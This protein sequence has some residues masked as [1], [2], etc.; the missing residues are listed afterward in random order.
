MIQDEVLRGYLLDCLACR[1]GTLPATPALSDEDWRTWLRLAT[2]HRVGPLLHWKQA[3]AHE[4]GW[5]DFLS[6]ALAGSRRTHALRAMQMQRE[7][8][9]AHRLLETAGIPCMALKGAF[10]AWHAYPQPDLRPV[11]DLD[12]LVPVDQ[13]LRAYDILRA[14]GYECLLEEHGELDAILKKSKHLPGLQRPD[15][16]VKLELHARLFHS[17]ATGGQGYELSQLPGFWERAIRRELGGKHIRYPAPTDQLLHLLVHAI[18]DHKLNNG[19]LIFTDIHYL[20]ETHDIDWLL[21]WQQADAL[22]Q[23]SALVLGLRLAEHHWGSLGIVWPPQPPALPDEA[24]LDALRY[25]SLCDVDARRHVSAMHHLRAGWLH[26]LSWLRRKVLP[27]PHR[28]ALRYPTRNRLWALPYWY[29][30][31]WLDGL[32]RLAVILRGPHKAATRN[33]L[34]VLQRLESWLLPASGPERSGPD[35]S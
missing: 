35:K 9:H 6:Q 2:M 1:T 25:F 18:A 4:A 22:Q 11:R 14:G 16:S 27:G 30:R 15:S 21:F 13:V 10:L 20:L 28:L 8:L 23:M 26:R 32:P 3:Q 17:D 29:G 19:P 12:L 7:L 24:L 31:N 33:E 34:G 5:P